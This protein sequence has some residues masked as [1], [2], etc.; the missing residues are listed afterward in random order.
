MSRSASHPEGLWRVRILCEQPVGFRQRQYGVHAQDYERHR[1]ARVPDRGQGHWCERVLWGLHPGGAK[2]CAQPIGRHD[3]GRSAAHDD[4]SCR[5]WFLFNIQ[6]F[7]QY[8]PIFFSQALLAGSHQQIRDLQLV[9]VFRGRIHLSI[10]VQTFR[11]IIMW[12]LCAEIGLY[13]TVE[14]FYIRWIVYTNKNG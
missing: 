9:G 7:V 8:F 12:M 5:L 13:V 1:E 2:I 10:G 4:V 6:A 11:W 14:I 3:S